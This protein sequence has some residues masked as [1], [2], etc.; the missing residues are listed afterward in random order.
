MGLSLLWMRSE[1]PQGPSGAF[2]DQG[3]R[4]PIKLCP[5]PNTEPA[6]ANFAWDA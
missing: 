4:G 1:G 6:Q 5:T 3:L 2:K